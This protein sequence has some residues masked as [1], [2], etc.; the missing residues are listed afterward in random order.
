MLTSTCLG[1]DSG[2]AHA[3]GNHALEDGIVDFMGTSVQQVF[4]L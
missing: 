3:L 4:S 1:N 2:L